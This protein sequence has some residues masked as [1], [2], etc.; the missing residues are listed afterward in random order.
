MGIIVERQVR[1]RS[2]ELGVVGHGS[3]GLMEMVS[4]GGRVCLVGRAWSEWSARLQ[5][6]NG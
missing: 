4:G 3:E 6:S 2:E 5:G 1:S